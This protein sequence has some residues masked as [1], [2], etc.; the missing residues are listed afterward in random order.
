MYQSEIFESFLNEGVVNITDP[1]PLHFPIRKFIVKRDAK[2]NII[3]TTTA[4]HD[5]QSNAEKHPP[6]TVRMNTDS[7]ILENIS[8]S[9]IIVSGVQLDKHPWCMKT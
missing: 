3:I 1:G 8:G 6:G 5:A 4:N 7:V 9:K 2:L